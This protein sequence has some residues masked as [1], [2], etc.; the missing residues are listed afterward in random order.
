[1]KILLADDSE[2][3]LTH[4]I[5]V[6]TKLGHEVVTATSGEQALALYKT[7]HPDLVILDV[8]MEEMDGFE[9]ARQIRVSQ[10]GN[11]V[12]IIFISSSVDEESIASGI[13]AGGD[14]YLAKPFSE[15]TFAAKIKAMQR[16]AE[17]R[18]TL[19]E[20]TQKLS[21]LSSIDTL[22]G[23]FNRAEFEKIIQQKLTYTDE[24]Q[25]I[26]ALLFIDLDNF[27][28]VND[29]LGHQTGDK[30]L[31]EVVKR[32]KNSIRSNDFLAR[33]GGDEFALVLTN[34]ENSD[35]PGLVA[36]RVIKNIGKTY[37][38][39]GH[40]INIGSSIGIA[41]YPS[42]GID[43][44]N[45]VRN[46]DI[47]M[48]HAKDLSRNSHYHYK[49]E[50]NKKRTKK[51]YLGNA[52]KSALDKNELSLNYQPVFNLKNKAIIG[53]EALL[54]WE[55]PKLNIV[56]PAEFVKIA[57]EDDLISSIGDWVIRTAFVQCAEWY[58]DGFKN[59]KLAINIST[60]QLLQEK[61]PE[62]I[63]ANLQELAI[64]PGLIELELT[65]TSLMTHLDIS[66]KVV[67][68]V[69]DIGISISIDDFG[70]GYSSLIYLKRM[71]IS[72]LKIDKA[73]IKDIMT[74]PN[75]AIIV[76]SLIGLG[77]NLGINITAEGIETEEHFKF[78]IAN[79]CPQ[80]QGYYLA[81][82]QCSTQM[83]T[84]LKKYTKK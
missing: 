35:I 67:K 72:T 66:E 14:D 19:Y 5:T 40:A 46:A 26:L 50:L 17:M 69:H 39:E 44:T 74:E 12:P 48:Y 32:I 54:C 41:C 22:T 8:I 2:D 7:I 4:A 13:N 82:P 27:K 68:D 75:D 51:G 15:I 1:M 43:K 34:I 36:K 10:Q 64:P 78:L 28:S 53:M 55:H 63:Q 9:C 37:D 38:I 21:V 65:E 84:L 49:P 20:V 42:E 16:I 79:E 76:K 23:V 62:F 6:I 25:T 24:S 45:L 47:A 71:P 73:F 18:Q 11:W 80:G 60:R 59:F 83:T 52:L 31:K 33:I 81:R 61:L 30:L 57:E 29:T 70:A 58:N 3:S 56:S 77:K